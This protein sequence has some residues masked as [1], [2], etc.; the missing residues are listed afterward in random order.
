[1]HVEQHHVRSDVGDHRDRAFHVGCLPDDVEVRL[2]RG[3]DTGAEH[4][5]VVDDG[6]ANRRRRSFAGSGIRISGSAGLHVVE[7]HAAE[8]TG[9][10]LP[11]IR[12]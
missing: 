12:S 6:H 4:L 2:Q 5:M 9:R 8:L 3:D 7:L 1:M 10:P 11:H